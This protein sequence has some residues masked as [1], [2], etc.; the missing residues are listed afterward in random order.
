MQ[1]DE[2]PFIFNTDG[3]AG[4]YEITFTVPY[5]LRRIVDNKKIYAGRA[6]RSV[7]YNVSES[8]DY[9]TFVSKNDAYKR[10]TREAAEDIKMRI[11]AYFASRL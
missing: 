2:Q 10:V 8:D 5:T 1:T 6:N 9:A 4:R 3:T 11:G 7:S